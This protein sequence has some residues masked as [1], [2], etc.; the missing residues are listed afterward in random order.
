MKTA[1]EV[2]QGLNACQ[3]GVD[4]VKAAASFRAAWDASSSTSDMSWLIAHTLPRARLVRAAVRCAETCA[5]L[6]PPEC[7]P[8]LAAVSAWANGEKVD[9]DAV[10]DGLWAARYAADAVLAGDSVLV[11]AARAAWDAAGYD[12]AAAAA[13]ASYATVW[14]SNAIGVAASDAVVDVVGAAAN[15]LH[16]YRIE[17]SVFCDVIRDEVDADEICA[18]MGIDP[19]AV[20]S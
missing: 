20:T 14:S 12:V 8:L 11:R 10:R 17:S 2:L 9:I 1:L 5:H 6:A 19:D 7:L 4:E 3:S 16:N 13:D 15:A 18:A